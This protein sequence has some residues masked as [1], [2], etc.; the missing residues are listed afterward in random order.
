MNIIPINVPF[1]PMLAR[2]LGYEGNARYLAAWWE[3][4]GD[5]V[6]ITDGRIGETGQWSAFLAFTDH[7]RVSPLLSGYN[8]GS[9]EVEA[10]YVLLVDQ[11]EKTISICPR[12]EIQQFLEQQWPKSP[13]NNLSPEQLE[14][15]LEILRPIPPPNISMEEV[16]I[17]MNKNYALEKEVIEFLDRSIRSN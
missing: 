4:G 8:L 13:S 3:P 2:A 11:T 9:S 6:W 17:N 16:E 1:P 14:K 7:I 5:E 10:E 15:A 12:G